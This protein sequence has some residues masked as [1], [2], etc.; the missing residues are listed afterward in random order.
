MNA[1]LPST[2]AEAPPTHPIPDRFG[3]NAYLEDAELQ[4]LLPLYLPVD[5]MAHLQPHLAR[6]GERVGVLEG[7]FVVMPVA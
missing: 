6:L 1:R 2:L 3:T 5:L 4:S 7:E